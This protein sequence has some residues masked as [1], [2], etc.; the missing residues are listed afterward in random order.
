MMLGW[1]TAQMCLPSSFSHNY[2]HIFFFFF[3]FF[4]N[5][6]PPPSK[7][8]AFLPNPDHPLAMCLRLG[9]MIPRPAS[10]LTC[11]ESQA[12]SSSLLS[13][14]SRSHAHHR[15]V[16]ARAVLQQHPRPSRHHRICQQARWP[17][18]PS[19]APTV[20]SF[21]STRKLPLILT[22]GALVLCV[23]PLHWRPSCPRVRSL[24]R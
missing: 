15:G 13:V 8:N 6:Q 11:Q 5:R 19:P 3:F 4:F 9:Y 21:G 23:R 24:A 7:L 22:A 10:E 18:P 17:W 14:A 2:T 16:Q 1:P 20:P 12:I